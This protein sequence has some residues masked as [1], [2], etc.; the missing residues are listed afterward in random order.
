MAYYISHVVINNVI[1]LFFFARRTAADIMI[2]YQ[3][4]Q[5]WNVRRNNK[6]EQVNNRKRKAKG[7]EGRR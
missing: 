4:C 5:K 2:N 7:W 6:V 1:S 3:K